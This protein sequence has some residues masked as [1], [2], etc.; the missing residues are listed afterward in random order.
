MNVV[1]VHGV[2]KLNKQIKL[3]KVLMQIVIGT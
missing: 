2:L 3:V 1:M